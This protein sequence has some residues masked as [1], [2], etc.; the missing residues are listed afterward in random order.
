MTD[1]PLTTVRVDSTFVLVDSRSEV[2]YFIATKRSYPAS[3]T[4]EPL[5][6]RFFSYHP[7]PHVLISGSDPRFHRDI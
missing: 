5:E 7:S 1:L 6:N 2:A 3:D 4:V